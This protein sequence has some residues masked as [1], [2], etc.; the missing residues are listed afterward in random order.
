MYMSV[1][2][3]CT[4]AVQKRAS[5]L[6]VGGCEPLYGCW[7][8]NSRPEEQPVL[9]TTEPPFQLLTSDILNSP[10]LPF[11]ISMF[12]LKNFQFNN[13]ELC[14]NTKNDGNQNKRHQIPSHT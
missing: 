1:L 10:P 3:A 7:V 4:S 5:D 11:Q 12:I 8:L 6:T 9:L 14:L 2:S 13:F